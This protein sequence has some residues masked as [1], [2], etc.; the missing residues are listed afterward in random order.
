MICDWSLHEKHARWIYLTTV[1]NMGGK[2][3]VYE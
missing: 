3:E 2:L 1:L